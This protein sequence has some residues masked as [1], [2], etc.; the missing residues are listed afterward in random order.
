V[1]LPCFDFNYI[2]AF[3][4]RDY[5]VFDD[6]QDEEKEFASFMSTD[7]DFSNYEDW[8]DEKWGDY[9]EMAEQQYSENYGDEQ[10]QWAE[11][12]AAYYQSQNY[13]DGQQQGYYYQNGQ[14]YQ[15]GG[16]S[17]YYGDQDGDGQ[18]SQ[19]GGQDYQNK[20]MAESYG[21][22]GASL[23][24]QGMNFYY[25]RGMAGNW[26]LS[27]RYDQEAYEEQQK[28][29]DEEYYYYKKRQA[30]FAN[31][32]IA[33]VCGALYTYAAKCN[34]HITGN[35]DSTSS[36]EKYSYGVSTIPRFLHSYLKYVLFFR[37]I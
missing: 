34:Q 29:E 1:T 28:E 13:Q 30:S 3:A 4:H 6:L 32:G 19:Y 17:Y 5:F 14:Q 37:Q 9:V 36:S 2:S 8:L 7:M 11:Q 22:Y 27:E 20:Q 10:N 12:Q 31:T 15:N 25:N 26:F 18:Y 35:S 16:G 21:N 23:L 33:D 24:N